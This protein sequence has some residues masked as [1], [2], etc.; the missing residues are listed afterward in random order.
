MNLFQFPL[1][2]ILVLFYAAGK[3]EKLQALCYAL[4]GQ[5]INS[6]LLGEQESQA[7]QVEDLPPPDEWEPVACYPALCCEDKSQMALSSCPSSSSFQA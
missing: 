1:F 5:D 7:E 3:S 4:T 6:L 2:L